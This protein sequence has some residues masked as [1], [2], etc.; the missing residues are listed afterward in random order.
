M[1]Q[2]ITAN[3]L[4]TRGVTAIS[5]AS[6]DGGEVFVSVRGKNRYVIIPVEKYNYFRECELDTAISETR[7][8][9]KKGKYHEESIEKHIK[10]I[11]R[12]SKKY[13]KVQ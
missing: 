5:D 1:S 4:K 9:I 3:D 7:N 13:K 11:T 6:S 10:R 8:D 2:I 12:L